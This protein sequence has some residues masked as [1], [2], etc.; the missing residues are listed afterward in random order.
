[1]DRTTPVGALEREYRLAG[2]AVPGKLLGR[3]S[4]VPGLSVREVTGLCLASIAVRRGKQAELSEKAETVLGVS[5]PHSGKSTLAWP[6]RLIW[7]GPGQWL[8]MWP[9]AEVENRVS[10]LAKP[11]SGVASVTDQSDSRVVLDVWGDKVRDVLSKGIMVDLHPRAFRTG[12]T[13]TTLAVHIGIQV[14]QLDD[15]PVYRLMVPRSY[16]LS[17][18]DWLVEAGQSTGI[19]VAKSELA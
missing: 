14:V 16:A 12:D 8:A 10:D 15:K 6:K 2:L 19:A 7:V 17:F 18:W 5:L 11:L 1:M 4:G 9:A 13:A 3:Q